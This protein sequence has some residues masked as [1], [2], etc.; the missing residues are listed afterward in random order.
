MATKSE[1]LK[2]LNQ[3][4]PYTGATKIGESTKKLD[5]EP[6]KAFL[7]AFNA[8]ADK[9]FFGNKS[10]ALRALGINREKFRGIEART[11]GGIDRRIGNISKGSVMQTTT[12]TPKNVRPLT[13]ITTDLKNNKNLL[14]K[15]VSKTNTNKFYTPKDIANIIGADVSD[16]KK[17]DSLVSDLKRFN[18]DTVEK[19]GQQKLYKF[20]D[21]MNKITKGYFGTKLVKGDVQSAT[22][23]A[24][25]ISKIDKPL[26]DFIAL[27]NNKLRNIS[28]DLDIFQ[29]N[30][31]EDVG[32][33]MSV[34][35]TDK[36]PK[37]FKNSNI[38]KLSTLVFQ[39]PE[40]NRKIL[41][42]TGY[43]S[44]HDKLFK[45]LNKLVGKEVT[46]QSQKEILK[47]KEEMNKLY[48]KAI[49]D[50]SKTSKSGTTLYNPRTKK[51]TT[52]QSPYFR[53]QENRIP[54]IN[55]NVPNVGDIFKSEN[56]FADMSKVDEAY[57]VGQA[58]KINPNAKVLN[59]LSNEEFIQFKNNFINQSRNNVEKFYTKAGYPASDIKDLSEA[60]DIGTD[61]RLP[62]VAMQ[63]Y[64]N[65]DAAGKIKLENRIG[66]SRGCFIKTIKEQPQKLI[67]L[68]RG[69]S[70]PQRNIQSMK[71]TAKHFGTTLAEM[72]KDKLSG[73][74][75]TPNQYHASSYLS[76]PG[77]MK[78]VDVTPAELESFNRYKAK[79]NKRPVKYSMK[80]KLGLPDPPTHGVTTSEFH[81]I[82]PRYKLKQMEEA[83]RLKK[84]LDINPFSKKDYLNRPKVKSTKGVLEYD[85]VL[86]GFVD[87]AN[88][89][90]IVGQNQLKAW[91]A[92]NPMPV[93]AG[94]S[95]K[96][97]F[98]R[99]T[100]RA[101][102][103][104][105]LPL[106]TAALD[107]Y[108]IGRQ[109]E[110]GRDAVDIAKDPFNW[111]GLATMDPLTRVTGMA[112][113][114]GKLASVMRLGM[115]PGMIRGATRF[116]GLPGLALST[117]LTAYDQYKK[118]QNKEGFIYDLF[119]KEEIDN[120]AV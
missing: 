59:D 9:N 22:K 82:I 29:P 95:V 35:I 116:L 37:L 117:G 86:G 110:E 91:A 78:Y 80:K 111:L 81:Q 99:K 65:A 48:N 58:H 56:I 71:S 115:S 40:I 4:K 30:A 20:G 66:C 12:R 79:V 55:I 50:I 1:V 77:Q 24:K 57:R 108:F 3:I 72:K 44:K 13:E 75:F 21:A 104:I 119:N 90:E 98:L 54:K 10:A 101:L 19:S 109:I 43:E 27:H 64:N 92:D 34:K 68:F 60:I 14:K 105:G 47:I 45:E 70:F 73:Q 85:V 61:S 84:T 16:K 17:L 67:R 103:H 83:G 69:E 96:P 113:K 33:A 38:N 118:Y 18:V 46:P 62:I 25:I 32:H 63:A 7:K 49:F 97:G 31:V 100:G 2:F 114:S 93:Q 26:N 107:S 89:S 52:L 74:W 41:E 87:S 76:R 11:L 102:A 39:D 5:R 8:Y 6:E 53:G 120:S 106:P 88:P 51:Y 42:A 36:Y 23:R 112:D 94:T 28:K 15:L